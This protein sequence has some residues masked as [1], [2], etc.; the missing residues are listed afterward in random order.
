M[1][2]PDAFFQQRL[3]LGHIDDE[4]GDETT[5]VESVIAPVRKGI[6]VGLCVFAELQRLEGTGQ[7]GLQIAE[8]SVDLTHLNAGRSRGLAAPTTVGT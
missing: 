5:Q 7:H 4:V 8:H 3:G 1:P 2:A 6:E